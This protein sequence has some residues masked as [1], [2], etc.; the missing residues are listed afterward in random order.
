LVFYRIVLKV[1]FFH[2]FGKFIWEGRTILVGHFYTKLNYQL[3]TTFKQFYWITNMFTRLPF[4]FQ[5]LTK[6]ITHRQR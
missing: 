1:K 5:F 6:R 2:L 4:N 3:K